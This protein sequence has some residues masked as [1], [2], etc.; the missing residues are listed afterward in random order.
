MKRR[1]GT[2]SGKLWRL[3]AAFSAL[4]FFALLWV[5]LDSL[6]AFSEDAH[7]TEV[8]IPDFCGLQEESLAFSDWMEV[9]MEYRYDE[10]VPTGVVMRQSPRAGS[11]RK[12]SAQ[13]PRCGIALVVSLGADRSPLPRVAG[14]DVRA[15]LELLRS[16]GYVVE[17]VMETGPYPE[18]TVLS[19]EPSAGMMMPRGATVILTVSAGEP[20][21]TVTVPD[22]RGLTRSEALIRLWLSRLTVAEVVEEASD[23]ERGSVIR[24]SHQPGTVVMAGTKVTI[25]V[26]REIDP[27][28]ESINEEKELCIGEAE[29]SSGATA[30]C[31]RCTCSPTDTNV[32]HRW[33]G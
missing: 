29:G 20:T 17:T 18:G 5:V 1:N 7:L 8:Q 9:R 26:S 24:Q 2:Q 6:F 16:Q 14:Q 19:S 23:A 32:P 13:H 33:T 4:L 15:A 30:D 10:E 11:T 3:S 12:L 27:K 28:E 25:Y 21:Q 22:V 31:L